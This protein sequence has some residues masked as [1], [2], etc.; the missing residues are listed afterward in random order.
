MTIW[1]QGLGTPDLE[2]PGNQ[3]GSGEGERASLDLPGE[4]MMEL[5]FP[6]STGG[7][8]APASL[9]S[10]WEK[11]VV[12]F[13]PFPRLLQ[14]RETCGPSPEG[15]HSAPTPNTF[16]SSKNDGRVSPSQNAVSVAG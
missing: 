2:Q 6:V 4:I 10:A 1:E 8:G 9:G 13:Y 5:P 3:G 7:R 11:Q 12:Q 14:F 16:S 15:Q